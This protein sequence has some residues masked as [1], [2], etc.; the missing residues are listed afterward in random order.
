[1]PEWL[2]AAEA[3]TYAAPPWW[4]AIVFF[5]VLVGAGELGYGVR[6]ILR[7]D[8][9][10]PDDAERDILT[11]AIGLLALMLAFTFAM[12][13]ERYDLRRGLVATEAG[14]IQGVWLQSQLVRNPERAELAKAIRSYVGVRLE[15]FEPGAH[16]RTAAHD[17]RSR[18]VLHDIWRLTRRAILTGTES[19]RVDDFA[20]P[21]TD[22]V[23]VEEERR[24]ARNA[25]VPFAVLVALGLY[26]TI[27]AGL[28]GFVMS[29]RGARHRAASTVLFAL[30]GLAI[31][32]TLDF[33]NPNNGFIML[34]PQPLL[35]LRAEMDRRPLPADIPDPLLQ[36]G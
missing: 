25:R 3:F 12:A 10:A 36:P 6:R 32:L 29:G 27:A 11:A 33:D 8:A 35:D 19:E 14:T 5:A 7:R 24:A 30:V 18:A 34:N 1:M 21:V 28:L 9:V 31:Y 20:F 22:M 17:E 26:S 16:A 4:A 23:R 2:R 15:G 13:H